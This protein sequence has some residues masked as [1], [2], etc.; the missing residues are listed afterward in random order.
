MSSHHIVREAQE[1]ALFLYTTATT[2]PSYIG[3]LLEWSPIVICT[4]NSLFAA[5]QN[6]IKVDV[7]ICP[8]LFVSTANALTNHQQPIQIIPSNHTNPIATLDYLLKKEH[9]A[10]NI[11]TTTTI[12]PADLLPLTDVLTIVVMD[13]EGNK[14]F[15]A[16]PPYFTK[17]LPKNQQIQM[18]PMPLV[19]DEKLQLGEQNCWVVTQTGTITVALAE[20][21]WITLK[22]L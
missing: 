4:E 7:V 20:P 16:T 10:V 21:C 22:S 2:L 17:W 12:N 9:Y 13:T 11:C 8:P 18:T 5:L 1:P 6:G 15:W 14:S 3:E 19:I